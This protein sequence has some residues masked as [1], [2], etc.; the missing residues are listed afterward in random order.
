MSRAVPLPGI[1]F[2]GTSYARDEAVFEPLPRGDARCLRHRE[3][4]RFRGAP[5]ALEQP[6]WNASVLDEAHPFP[7]RP[8]MHALQRYE[9]VD[10]IDT[11]FPDSV[12]GTTHLRTRVRSPLWTMNTSG[13]STRKQPADAIN[14][15]ISP[16]RN[17]LAR[18]IA[19]ECSDDKR[20]IR[21]G[22]C[23][24]T[25][26]WNCAGYIGSLEETQ[27]SYVSLNKNKTGVL[28]KDMY[29]SPIRRVARMNESIRDAKRS[30]RE[31]KEQ[32]ARTQT[33]TRGAPEVFKMSNID[34]W[35]LLDPTLTA[36]IA[37]ETAAVTAEDANVQEELMA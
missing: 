9:G 25:L 13:G 23:T 12:R 22:W 24:S 5:R 4:E 15:T 37:E 29:I 34:E 21:Q 11:A 27:K 3:V 19:D 30:E 2:A 6:R 18:V 35:W 36:T 33:N 7:Q 14:R 32:A 10:V 20:S 8:I 1:T 31:Q 28:N 16:K 26:T 17:F